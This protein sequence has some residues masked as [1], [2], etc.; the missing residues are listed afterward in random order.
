MKFKA[1]ILWVS[2]LKEI[3]TFKSEQ[4]RHSFLESNE[5]DIH[6]VILSVQ[7]KSFSLLNSLACSDGFLSGLTEEEIDSDIYT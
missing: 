7:E 3:K 2:G 4:E 5:D 1:K 6:Y